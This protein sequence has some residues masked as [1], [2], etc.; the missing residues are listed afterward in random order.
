MR[1]I[2]TTIL[3]HCVVMG[4]GLSLYQTSAQA[5]DDPLSVLP[6]EIAVKKSF[7][8]MPQL[9]ASNLGIRLADNQKAKLNAG[10]YEWTAKLGLNRRSEQLGA[11][12]QEQEFALERPLRWFGKADKD[13]AIGDKGMDVAKA[14]YADQ[15]HEASRS[16]MKDW[17]D[18][19]RES[20]SLVTLRHQVEIA[21]QLA[22]IASKRV[23]AGDVARLEQI[24]AE[25]E[26]QRVR[27]LLQQAEQRE[28]LALQQLQMTYPGLPLPSFNE[29]PV[30]KN[31]SETDTLSTEH[32]LHKI[33]DDNHE[34]E[35]AQAEAAYVALQAAR[36]EQ[37]KMP[38]PTIGIRSSRERNGQERIMGLSISIPFPGAARQSERLVAITKSQ[39]AN[40][41]MLQT[42]M[43]VQLMAQKAITDA[44]RNFSSW[45]T[46]DRL[47]QQS[48]Q[49]A[50]LMQK[51]YQLGEVGISETL[52]ARKNAS[53]ATLAASSAQID[54]LAAYARLHLD[55]HL[56][57]ALEEEH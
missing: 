24:S 28:E 6:P 27:A 55:A 20:R 19:M 16:L 21:G 54:A 1:R 4:M 45:Q 57:W 7:S 48:Q 5:N 56:I 30:P 53:D 38:D 26:L 37:D 15:W 18:A 8:M 33:M 40:E 47:S 31:I 49:Q 36:I 43:K 14:S 17:F 51:A 44:Q 29:L 52:T 39:I 2:K 11:S 42:Q 13:R 25:T 41:K 9:R 3:Y 50:S 12:Y 35:L 32:W 22:A 10:H 34:L 46:L 23:K